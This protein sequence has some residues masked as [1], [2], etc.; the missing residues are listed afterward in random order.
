[1]NLL[2]YL[3]FG[4]IVWSLIE[5][6]VNFSVRKERNVFAHQAGKK[7]LKPGTDGWVEGFGSRVHRDATET[8]NV[9][10]PRETQEDRYANSQEVWD[11]EEKAEF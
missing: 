10:A 5:F 9:S 6:F 3:T 7:S 2:Q 8:L 1:M 11:E 4:L